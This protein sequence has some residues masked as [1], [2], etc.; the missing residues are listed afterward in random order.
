MLWDQWLCML[1]TTLSASQWQTYWRA[2][3]NIF[4]S[5]ALPTHLLSFFGDILNTE[6]PT[7][8]LTNRRHAVVISQTNN[9]PSDLFVDNEYQ[10]IINCESNFF[11]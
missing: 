6:N 10:S 1:A 2:Y 4:G 5:S 8:N 7:P 9:F 11:L 3:A